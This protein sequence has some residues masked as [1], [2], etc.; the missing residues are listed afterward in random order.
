MK[1]ITL[2]SFIIFLSLFNLSAKTSEVYRIV[3]LPDKIEF[4]E[5][6]SLRLTK[7]MTIGIS[8]AYANN[9]D[10]QRCLSF[11]E[12]YIN[13]MMGWKWTSG[14]YK[15]SNVRLSIDSSFKNEDEYLIVVGKKCV[16][17][18][19]ATPAAVFYGVQAFRQ[20][21]L[22]AAYSSCNQGNS[23]QSLKKFT[24]VE[25]P[26]AT[27]HNSPRF[28]YRGTHFDC[29]RHFFS[30]DF[31]KKYIDILAFHGIN[32]FHWHIT[33]DQGWRFEVKRYPKLCEIG[34]QRDGTMIA[35]DFSSFDG[36]PYGGYYTQDECRE[37]VRYAAERFIE[38]IPEV[39]MPGHMLGALAAYPELGC[40]GGPY[41][42]WHL[43]GIADDVLCAGN[44][45]TVEFL[46][47]VLDELCDVFPSKYI[48]LGGDECPKVRWQECQRCQQKAKELGLKAFTKEQEGGSATTEITVENQLQTYL[49]KE[50]ES[51]LAA[52]GRRVIGWDEVL[53]GGLGE[54]TTIMSWRGLSGGY[55][56]ARLGHD[57]IMCPTTNCYLNFYQS[58]DW[59]N[60]P[61]SFKADL[62]IENVYSLEPVPEGLTES[63]QKHILGCQ[64][65]L[66]TE[67][68]TTPS[69]AEYMLLPRLAAIV[70]TQ[71]MQPS[72]KDFDDFTS[73]L[74]N[75]RRVYDALGFNHK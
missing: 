40:T 65:N 2:F 57:V 56:A 66:W 16:E 54:N 9:E 43:W 30:V 61:L 13:D 5:G 34:S 42:V 74:V 67:Y 73:R 25:M 8:P 69:Q 48:H 63:E 32:R 18:K 62:P 10:M 27:I 36:I 71:W 72:C 41:K 53:E 6:A 68:I 14:T 26:C 37:I 64:A 50:A 4:N 60:E 11:F 38:V 45:K 49:L 33:D 22:S 70:E 51:F 28:S 47:G 58:S 39:D 29:S 55:E 46:K 44:P 35:H 23:T 12:G 17:I 21:V 3:P 1:R 31:V 19:G 52:K 7:S 75:L 24:E 20:M 15:K 59:A